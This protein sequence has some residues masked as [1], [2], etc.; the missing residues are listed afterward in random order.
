MP[1]EDVVNVMREAIDVEL[2]RSVAGRTVQADAFYVRFTYPDAALAASVTSSLGALFIAENARERKDLAD[3]TNQFLEAQLVE[4]KKK[5]EAQEGL[6]ERFRQQ[7]AGRLPTQSDSNVQAMQASQAQLTTLSASLSQ[8]RDRRQ[9][10]QVLY[11][12]AISQPDPV[13]ALP[14]P[15]PTPGAPGVD[16]AA[17]MTL[18]QQLQSAKSTL[19]RL[20]ARLTDEHPDLRRQRR[21]VRDLEQKIQTAQKTGQPQST[22]PPVLTESQLNRRERLAQIK[23]EIDTLARQI[24]YKETEEQKLRATVSDYQGRLNAM[25]GVESQWIAL[26]RDYETMKTS[27][28]TLLRKSEDS[29]VAADLESQQAGEQFRIVDS[30]RVPVRPVGA[31]RIRTNAVGVAGGLGLGVLIVGLLFLRDTT[32]HSEADVLEVLSLPVLALVPHVAAPSEAITRKRRRLYIASAV[33][34]VVAASGYVAWAKQLW[35]FLT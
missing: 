32:F 8:D 19:E 1:M 5:L 30:A 2:V 24:A 34:V 26:T 7:H 16:P 4:A 20:E 23:G 21:V 13:S 14:V 22:A 17:G 6:V 33:L 18:E 27:Y 10:L 12:D 9:T 25:P 31:K 28:E 11:N 15:A 35:K 29:K 3:G